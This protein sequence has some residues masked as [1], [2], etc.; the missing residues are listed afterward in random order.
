MMQ[1]GPTWI[2]DRSD[3]W[4]WGDTGSEI[5]HHT[6]KFFIEDV[7]SIVP[8]DENWMDG[9]YAV[10]IWF[11]ADNAAILFV[12]GVRVAYTTKALAGRN[13]P[14]WEGRFLDLSHDSFDGD[15]WQQIYFADI[16]PFLQNGE[17]TLVFYAANSEHVAGE[18]KNS[19]Y[20]ITN[21]PCGLIFAAVINM[22]KEVIDV[23]EVGVDVFAN[24][25]APVV[26]TYGSPFS[27]VTATNAGA[28]TIVPNSN[29]FTFATLDRA[30]LVTGVE[31]DLVVGNGLNVVGKATAVLVD[32]KVE[33]T[34]VGINP[35]ASW[36]AV[37]SATP[38]N[39]SNGNVHS[40]QGDP[41]FSHK[42]PGLT[43]IA[44]PAGNGPIYLYVHFNSVRF[45][46]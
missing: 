8:R 34:F 5:I 44:A 12:N 46:Q 3:S 4:A 1:Y 10:P 38:F 41:N 30:A 42:A 35:L 7:E 39:P 17:N 14:D 24:K 22:T 29:H 9:G 37:V 28:H 6:T 13:V 31:L 36:G 43:S 21:N 23:E 19:S 26:I 2:W 40:G 33:L 18:T 11:A 16:F 45:A 15:A 27:S 25:L 20:N 32:G